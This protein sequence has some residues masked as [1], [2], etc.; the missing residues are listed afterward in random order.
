MPGRQPRLQAEVSLTPSQS[1]VGSRRNGYAAHNFMAP[2]TWSNLPIY[3]LSPILLLVLTALVVRTGKARAYPF[4]LAYILLRIL[5]SI[6]L[7][8][9]A[10][11]FTQS[12][13]VPLYH[14]YFVAF[15]SIEAV[16]ALLIFVTLYGVFDAS[17]SR[18][19][20]LSSW[21][22]VLFMLAI[23]GCLVVSILVT[24]ATVNTRG[25]YSLLFPLL[26]ASMLL[27]TGML[28]FLFLFLFAFGIGISARD[29]QFGM[30]VGL[31]LNGVIVIGNTATQ[32]LMHLEQSHRFDAIASNTA[33][34]VATTIWMAYLFV[35]QR[36]MQ[37]SHELPDLNAVDHWKDA[38]SGFLQR[39]SP[40]LP[41]MIT[42]LF[43]APQTTA[44]TA[45][46]HAPSSL[47]SH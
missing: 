28:A 31:G 3:V 21:T 11:R 45:E 30:T 37:S 7:L 40:T 5:R 39:L 8:P 36:T 15:W 10:F 42:A 22:G 32:M 24:P 43:P 33:D 2:V 9:V 20:S 6:I 17:F 34:F 19:P 13:S 4:F 27:R 1:L 38:L 16:L 18:Y 14:V 26:Q 35:P 44:A 46:D 41:R 23:A 29:Y 47:I 25:A 12:P